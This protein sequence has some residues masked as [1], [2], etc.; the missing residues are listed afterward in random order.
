MITETRKQTIDPTS[1][2]FYNIRELISCTRITIYVDL[3]FC[4]V[5]AQQLVCAC[6]VVAPVS[7]Y[8]LAEILIQFKFSFF[9]K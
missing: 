5:P 1:Q 2:N 4:E 7:Q 3:Y 9:V 6:A 8:S